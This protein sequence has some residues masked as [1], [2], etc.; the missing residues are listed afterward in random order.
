MLSIMMSKSKR[1]LCLALLPK[2]SSRMHLLMQIFFPF[3]SCTFPSRENFNCLKALLLLWKLH[4][5]GLEAKVLLSKVGLTCDLWSITYCFF[6]SF[7]K[8]V[9]VCPLGADSN[10][11]LQ[12]RGFTRKKLCWTTICAVYLLLREG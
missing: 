9:L 11:L 12:A 2:N 5:Y 7:T 4:F 3:S 10:W 6:R 1:R 8:I